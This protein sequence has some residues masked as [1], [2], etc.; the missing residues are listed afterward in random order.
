VTLVFYW[1]TSS[2]NGG[3]K[4]P[5]EHHRME[6]EDHGEEQGLWELKV[7]VVCPLGWELYGSLSSHPQLG[8]TLH[9]AIVFGLHSLD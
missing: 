2:G 4:M 6:R 3:E 7:M 5:W 1:A 9:I 8:C